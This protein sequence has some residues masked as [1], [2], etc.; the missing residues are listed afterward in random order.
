MQ[1]NILINT[2]FCQFCVYCVKKKWKKGNIG[3]VNRKKNCTTI[4]LIFFPYKVIELLNKKKVHCQPAL[5]SGDVCGS[6]FSNN[7]LSAHA[8]FYCSW[9]LC[10]NKLNLCSG[11]VCH[12]LADTDLM[13][14]KLNNGSEP[15]TPSVSTS[16]SEVCVSQRVNFT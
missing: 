8:C 12:G 13:W 10:K 4:F 5:M 16:E 11:E 3:R 1:S 6:S 2:I 7:N 15:K 14:I 9:I